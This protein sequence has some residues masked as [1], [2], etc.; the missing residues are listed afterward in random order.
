ME[1]RPLTPPLRHYLGESRL[2]LDWMRGR[3]VEDRL[4][5][6]HP[7]DGHPVIVLPGLFTTD[8]RTAML[9][10]V[11]NKAGYRAHG[12]GL[13]RNMPVR[14]DVLDRFDAHVQAVAK[15]PVT[16]IGWSLGGL[17]AR[18]YAQHAPDRVARVIT[19]G[20]PFSGDPRSNRAWQFYE[21]FADHK[22]DAPPLPFDLALKPPVATTAIWSAR[23][24]I[25]AAHSARG[26]PHESDE[27]IEI[28]CGHLAMSS[29][30]DALEAVLKVLAARA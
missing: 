14:V 25:I 7:G 8:N 9:R 10:R 28:R 18:A 21:L 15:E 5:A 11:L 22:V 2:L 30:P 16:L 3:M 4:A 23:D 29:A 1:T 19:L 26:L 12:W 24:G 13:G 6:A 27:T 17:I 20:S